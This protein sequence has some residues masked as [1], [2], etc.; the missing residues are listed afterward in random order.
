M[1]K[2]LTANTLDSQHALELPNREMLGLVTVVIAN[3]LNHLTVDVD[4]NNNKVGIEVCAAVNAIN[5]I[6]VGETLTCTIGQ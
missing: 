2:V 4:V 1:K 6:L 3:V 5:T